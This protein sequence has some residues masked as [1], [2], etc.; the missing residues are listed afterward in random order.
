MTRYPALD[1]L[2]KVE[3][4]QQAP[5]G[6]AGLAVVMP[7]GDEKTL[8]RLLS[9]TASQGPT[10]RLESQARYWL[11]GYRETEPP[12]TRAQR[13][14]LDAIIAEVPPLPHQAQ[15]RQSGPA[16]IQHRPLMILGITLVLI[17]LI[18]CGKAVVSAVSGSSQGSPP[19]AGA[20]VNPAQQPAQGPL[21]D[22]QQ[23]RADWNVPAVA[24]A[25]A[26]NSQVQL[27]LLQDGLYY[28]A[29]WAIPGGDSG[30]VTDTSAGV[31]V[32]HVHNGLAYVTDSDGT[33]WTVAV[34][35][36]FVLASN[37]QVI[38]RVLR[39]GTIQSVPEPHAI[40]V[41]HRI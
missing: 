19:A 9:E 22:L 16:R 26:G 27:V 24:S 35:Q 3:V 32:F 20:P 23:F 17:G 39:D 34:G 36:P 4:W 11:V 13:E 1:F 5:G 14:E 8:A 33:M 15:V 31:S 38:F 2:R 7:E 40:A 18:F 41:R 30:W 12:L 29:P 21:T 37:P 6:T 25:S 10:S 28:P